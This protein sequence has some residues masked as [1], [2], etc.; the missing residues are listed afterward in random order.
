[1]PT[2]PEQ[3][4]APRFAV[5]FAVTPDEILET[6]KLRYQIFAGEM[7]ASIDGGEHGVDADQY[8]AYC[9]HMVVRELG[10]NRIVACTRLLTDDQ[11]PRAGGYYSSG[12]FDISMLDSLPGRVMEVGRTCV[13]AE[14]R[15]GAV[16]ATLWT[17]LADFIISNG[18]DY[19]F[20]CASIPLDD[21]GANAHAVIAQL[22]DKYMAPAWQRVRPYH[23]FPAADSPMAP[24]RGR[25]PP[26]LKAYISLGLKACGEPYWDQDFNCADVFMLLNV[27]DMHPRYVRHFLDRGKSEETELVGHA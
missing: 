15:S 22:K 13:A 12:E 14:Y 23:P 6:Q 7:G 24:Q 20:G 16:I 17:G 21:G 5:D 25:M 18:F 8:D 3:T 27:S 10:S 9:R 2:R 11:A 4:K 19:L 1:M 26:L